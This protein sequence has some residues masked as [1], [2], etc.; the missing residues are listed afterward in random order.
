M[1]CEETPVA[2][3]WFGDPEKRFHITTSSLIENHENGQIKLM[4]TLNI[5]SNDSFY[6]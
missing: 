6:F 3:Q 2:A 1:Y 5:S 4:M